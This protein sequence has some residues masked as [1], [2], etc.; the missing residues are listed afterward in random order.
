MQDSALQDLTREGDAPAGGLTS[1]ERLIW[2]GQRLDPGSPLYNMALAVD[3]GGPIDVD[4]LGQAFQSLVD[5]D[6]SLR[7]VFR[8][9][10]GR[11][12]RIVLSELTA[13]VELIDMHEA[14][15]SDAEVELW[16]AE[17]TQRLLPLHEPLFDTC[18]V[19]RRGDRFVLFFNQ[20]H[21]ATDAWSA[22]VL[23]RRLGALYEHIMSGATGP[24]AKFPCFADYV[25]HERELRSSSHL[26]RAVE[27]WE[28]SASGFESEGPLYGNHSKGSGRTHRIRVP[29][30]EERTVELRRLVSEKP[31]RSLTVE[32]SHYLVFATLLLAWLHRASDRGAVSIGSPW[33]NRPS[34]E[35]RETLGLFIELYPLRVTIDDGETLASLAS[36]VAAATMQTMR[37]V[38]PGASAS[39]GA[40]GYSAVLN[41]ITASLGDFAGLPARAN[42]IHSGHGDRDHKIRLQVH[43]FDAAGQPTLDFDLD[44]EVFDSPA[45]EWAIRHFLGL[46]DALAGDPDQ[47]IAD[48]PLASWEEVESYAPPGPRLESPS[49]VVPGFRSAVAEHAGAVAIVDGDH[50]VTYQELASRVHALASRLEADGVGRGDVVGICL[51]RSA[52][53]VV[54]IMGALEAGAAYVPMDPGYPDERLSFIVE[55][56][57][58]AV[59]LTSPELASR[60]SGWATRTVAFAEASTLQEASDGDFTEPARRTPSSEDLAYVLYTSGSTGQPKGVEVTHGALA[61]YVA[62]AR[63][64][65]SSGESLRFPL[66]TSP[67]F[68]LTV[69][70]IF[71]PLLSGGAIVVYREDLGNSGLLVR[72]VFEDDG[73]DIVKLTPSHLALLRDL[74]L[75]RSRVRRLIVGGEDLKTT[76][77]R[78]A[79]DAFG[80]RIEIYN[81]YG[82]TEA[83]VG[84][85]VHRFDPEVDTARSV[86]IGVPADNATVHVL[87]PE[88]RPVVRGARGEICIRGPGLARGYR[89]RPELTDR[90]FELLPDPTSGSDPTSAPPGAT[91][92]AGASASNQPGVRMYR[93]GDLGRWNA[94]G[95]LEFL[96]RRDDQVKIRGVR[97]ELGEVEAAL[98]RHPAV[99]EAAAN[100]TRVGARSSEHC[101]ACGLEASH[102]EAQLDEQGIC[103]VCTRFQRDRERVASYFGTMADLADIFAR[104]SRSA[105][106][107]NDTLMLYSGGKDS[108]YALCRI[109]EMGC[110]PLVFTLDN[111]FIS[112]EAK[113]NV[114]RVVDQ[115]GL[116]LVVGQTPAMP[117]IFADSLERFSNVCN[118]CFKTIYTL[119]TNLAVERGIHTIV[120]GLSRGQIFETRLADLYRR[121]IYDAATVDQTILEARKAYHRMDDQVSRSLDVRIFESDEVFGSVEFVDF[122]RYCDD[123]LDDVLAYVAE[124]TPWIRPSDTGRSTNCLINQAGI[125]VHKT[126]RGFHNY[127][128]PYSWDVRLGHKNRD[129]AMEELDDDL[130]PVAIQRMLQEVGYRERETPAPESRLMAFYTAEAEV[131]VSELRRFLAQSL[132]GDAMPSAFVHLERMPLTQNGKIDRDALPELPDERPMLEV[133][134][135][136]P[137]T[138]VEEQLAEIWGDVL[139]LHAIGIED[140][141]FELGGDSMHCIQIVSAALDSGLAFGPRDLFAHPTV[142]ALAEVTSMDGDRAGPA[143]ATVSAAELA[144]LEEEFG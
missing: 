139:G 85:T 3:I 107:P 39:P 50:E 27:H 31:F 105:A 144:E 38:V 108:T 56:S 63:R 90:A 69:T 138:P 17:R 64:T 94:A 75:T 58:A 115:L 53:L 95:L 43:D 80:G 41:Y 98:A 5:G 22:G 65:Y 44:S 109:V 133:A 40:R 110:Q 33:H 81:E 123:T 18:I 12:C 88:G 112:E 103:A 36:K 102:P 137:R 48:V 76:T 19:R 14:D 46:F 47:S 77:A 52:D 6:E 119:A 84:C 73:V 8:E 118:G 104:S 93:T 66:F 134:Y 51:G 117:G 114:R 74:D 16:L 91:T 45:R 54:A 67:A 140:N 141:F 24:Q 62:W 15:T 34:P 71:T 116:E 61:D 143:P 101:E 32:Q 131:P 142:A 111:G 79:H 11:P 82:P 106:G 128:L 7:T 25:A 57:G 127:T 132:P 23:Y 37:H 4:A 2:A 68:D 10:E 49:S 20:H 42:W 99:S 9:Q 13:D 83:T 129:A 72:H 96:G 29:L 87:D 55:D 1:A 21:I 121:G 70:S 100:V 97:L 136:Q 89:G 28:R 120:T 125:F 30:G 122:Y 113:T 92:T 135:V 59:V 130:D 35:L 126:E 26:A 78:S 124:H 86:A 60:M